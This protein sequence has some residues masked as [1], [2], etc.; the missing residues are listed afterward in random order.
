MG[1]VFP[2]TDDKLKTEY[3]EEAYNPDG[4]VQRAVR[5]L[6]KRWPELIV[7]TDVALDPYNVDGHDGHVNGKGVILN[8]ESV[9][10]LVKQAL[11]HAHAGA[12]IIAPSDMQDGRVLAIRRA[13]DDAGFSRVLILSY[14]A[15]YASAF[16]GPFREALDSAPK[17]STESKP[18]PSHKRTYQMDPG[19]KREAIREARCDEAEGA[20]IMMVKPAMCYLDIIH[21]LRETS[22]LPIAAYQVSG[23]YA[24]IKAACLN[25]WL[26]EKHIVME[27]LLSIRRAGA[28][29]IF[30][31]FAREA[32]RWLREDMIGFRHISKNGTLKKWWS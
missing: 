27:S 1:E 30:T 11:S 22:T 19:N 20:D 23:E 17:K 25:N 14:T 26:E 10:T 24:M 32:S 18:I 12:D 8:D 9:I 16:Y 3:S 7:V 4:L 2:A 28:D 21:V 13:L 5:Q 6:K 29:I 15:K 31:Y